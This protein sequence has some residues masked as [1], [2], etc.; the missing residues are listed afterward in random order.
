M[1]RPYQKLRDLMKRHR[2]TQIDL[3]EELGLLS[4]CTVSR[5]LNDRSPWTSDEMYRILEV[6]GV[7]YE[8]MHEIF[9]KNG[10][11]EEPMPKHTRRP[12]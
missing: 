6:L 12:A 3:A 1:A 11:N 10:R 4:E 2:I 8:R 5:K 7:N 9:P